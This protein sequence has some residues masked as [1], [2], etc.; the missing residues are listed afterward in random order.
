V[1]TL[2]TNGIMEEAIGDIVVGVLEIGAEAAPGEG[3]KGCGCLVLSI[4]VAACILA[5]YFYFKS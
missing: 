1:G 2:Q 5:G 3:K 4:I